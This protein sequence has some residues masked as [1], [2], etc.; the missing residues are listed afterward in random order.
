[1]GIFSGEE[2]AEFEHI[3]EEEP[4]ELGGLADKPAEPA[5]PAE[6]AE[7]AEPAESAEPA[8]FAELWALERYLEF[9]AARGELLQSC[10]VLP[11]G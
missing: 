9:W 11:D 5:E 7:P 3:P 6:L 8:E 10:P 2:R 1:M 4:F